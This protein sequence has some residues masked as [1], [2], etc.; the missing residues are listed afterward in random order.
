[1]TTKHEDQQLLIDYLAGQCDES[2]VGEVRARLDRDPEFRKQ[3]E[4]LKGLDSVLRLLPEL[5]PPEG[6]V[7]S[8]MARIRQ[9]RR[10]DALLAREGMKSAPSRGLRF[11]LR[12]FIASAAVVALLAC[13]L[14]PAFR[15]P[16]R[17]A[18]TGQ[19]ASRAGQIGRAMGLF[20]GDHEDYLP[21]ARASRHWLPTASPTYASN[22]E[23]LFKLVRDGYAAPS[24]FQ[25]PA[26]A[27]PENPGF[28]VT[29][30]MLDFPRGDYVSYSYQHTLGPNSIRRGQRA[31]IAIAADMA[32]L[33][34]GTPLFRQGRFVPERVSVHASDNSD[35]H[36]GVGQN[37]LYLDMH[38]EWKDTPEA[39]VMGNNIYLAEGVYSYRG[40]ER[41]SGPTDTFLLPAWSRRP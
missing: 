11:S 33:A 31:L 28:A 17:L 14:V 16:G 32:I 10:T 3:H 40:S 5:E 22:S 27:P 25:C 24:V 15:Q 30:G 39:G 36:D 41:P 37:V 13:V 8:T 2:E 19:C 20:A 21:S 4:G 6:L 7:D 29:A 1:M 18:Q 12:E 34:D 38:V 26:V 23:G 35:N 9:K